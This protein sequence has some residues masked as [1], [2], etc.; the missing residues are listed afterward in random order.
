M[1]EKGLE[2]G[3][4][5]EKN[6]GGALEVLGVDRSSVRL[7]AG[8]GPHKV[9]QRLGGLVHP[10][11]W[12]DKCARLIARYRVNGGCRSNITAKFF[13]LV[14]CTLVQ[15][16]KYNAEGKNNQVQAANHV[17]AHVRLF[18]ERVPQR[19]LHVLAEATSV[20]LAD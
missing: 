10:E 16:D 19:L 11:G 3:A 15:R 1:G 9:P 5:A 2:D 17:V 13:G 12:W 7:A 8:V 18:F 14:F 4:E 20:L 6:Y